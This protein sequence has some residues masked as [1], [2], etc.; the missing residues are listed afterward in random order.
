MFSTSKLLYI[1]AFSILLNLFAYPIYLDYRSCQVWPSTQL[2]VCNTEWQGDRGSGEDVPQLTS[3]E[4]LSV[5]VSMFTVVLYCLG[6]V[7]I[8]SWN[9]TFHNLAKVTAYKSTTEQYLLG[10]RWYQML[11]PLIL[12]N[13]KTQESVCIFQSIF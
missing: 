6:I 9:I 5:L 11:F 7:S 1:E 10:L 13:R 2:S 3:M 12:L 4:Q 8:I